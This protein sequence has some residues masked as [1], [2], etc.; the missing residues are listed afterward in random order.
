MKKEIL[1]G[2]NKHRGQGVLEVIIALGVFGIIL[3]A[4]IMYFFGGQ[5]ITLDAI[6]SERAL[7]FARTGL[8]GTRVI[9]DQ[10]WY[11]LQD[12]THGLVFDQG[13]WQ[14]SGSSDSHDEFKRQIIIETTDVNIKKVTTRV[15]WQTDPT[16]VQEVELVEYITNWPNVSDGWTDPTG[17]WSNPMTL[18]SIDAGPAVE[19]QGVDME[20]TTAYLAAKSSNEK[21]DDLY[22]YDMTD[23]SNPTLVSQTEVNKSNG[24][25]ELDFVNDKYLFASLLGIDDEFVVFDVSL[26]EFPTIIATKDI[27]PAE[28]TGLTSEDGVMFLST[29]E[30][31]GAEF[32]AIDISVP[33]NPTVIGTFDVGANVN[34]IFILNNRAYLATDK[35][36]GSLIVLDISDPYSMGVIGSSQNTEID[37]VFVKSWT[38]TLIGTNQ[39]LRI[40]NTVDPSSPIEIGAYSPDVAIND[41]VAVGYLAFVATSDPNKEFQVVNIEDVAN[42][43]L[44]S[45]FNFPQVASEIDYYDNLVFTSVRSNDALRVITSNP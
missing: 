22:I 23:P 13:M 10:N 37:A 9:R 5:S 43:Y 34:D 42:P 32:F 28:A 20:G 35:P 14:L 33:S 15:T 21:K 44:Y 38:Q 4:G 36:S 29:K 31:A 16:R 25:L 39:E 7:G 26:P 18:S 3:G 11:D 24:I 27:T 1:I 45:Y 30:N 17:D 12:G 2:K 6:N 19:G 40:M 41:V 8:E